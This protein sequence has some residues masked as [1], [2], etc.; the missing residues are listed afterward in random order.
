M[1]RYVMAVC[2]WLAMSGVVAL[3][4][5]EK[6]A[7]RA[8]AG[9][10]R[11][12]NVLNYGAL[13]D[14][15]TDN[16]AAFS[17]C[18]KAVIAAGGGR[19]VL[20]DGV[21]RGRILIPGTRQWITVE[22]VGESEPTPVFGTIGS[23]PLP[24][25]GTILKCLAD[26]GPAVIKA[27]NTPESLYGGFSGVFVI[28]RNLDVRTYDN[29][30]IGGVDLAVAAQCKVENVFINT[31]VYNVQASKPTHRV[32]GLLT[33]ACA[34]GALTILRN[35]VVT[36]YESGILV[37]EHTDGDNIVVAS[38]IHGLNFLFA[39]HAS[40]FGRVGAYRNTHHVTVSGKHGFSIEQLNTEFPGP[41][42]TDARNAWQTLVS[43]INDPQNLGIADINYWCVKG[44][45]GAVEDFTRHG[46]AG[47]RARRIGSAPQE[48]NAAAK[49]Q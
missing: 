21:Y 42:Q 17:A 9:G 22:I 29:P 30:C 7:P 45:V 32:T 28:V 18:V 46:G 27:E 41:G 34:N 47:V 38:N 37:N 40:R 33:P 48:N 4:A 35:V 11:V 12:F 23:F 36:G 2:G 14:D 6:A 24:Q 10:P 26:S 19:M 8:D 43:D 39:A 25:S 15:K 20:P 31:G 49:S 5:D 13:G 16:T 1:N 3:Y 44:N